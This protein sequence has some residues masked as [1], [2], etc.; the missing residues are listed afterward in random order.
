M[1]D[2]HAS[3]LPGISAANP[4][5]KIRFVNSHV[6]RQFPDQFAPLKDVFGCD[7]ESH[8]HGTMFRFPLRTP[9]LADASEIKR[10]AYSR[11]EVADLFRRFRASITE[12]MLFLRNV[13]NVEVYVQYEVGQ[14]PFL[15]FGTDVAPEDDG[16][17]WKQIDEFVRGEDSTATASMSSKRDF[18]ARLSAKP[19][20]ELPSITQVVRISTTEQQELAEF[21]SD[22]EADIVSASARCA[23]QAALNS[24]SSSTAQYLVC[25]RIGGGRAREMACAPENVS[26]KLIPWAGIAGRIDGVSTE[27]RA[28][29]FLPLP[30]RV[31]LPVH[32]NGYFE[33]S[34]N[35]RDVWHG[36]DMTGE[37]KLR[38]EWNASLL[39]DAV[40]PAYIAFLLAARELCGE[41][42]AQ[43]LALFPTRL[44][45]QPWEAIVHELFRRMKHHPVFVSH[46]Q[47][48]DLSPD[49]TS[50]QLRTST[51]VAPADCV[52]ID[53][54]I[55]R[56][57]L[58]ESAL[59]TAG[60]PTVLLPEALRKLAI[61]LDTV[62]SAMTPAFFRDLVRDG[63][64]LPRLDES[65]ARRVIEFCLHDCSG[66]AAVTP[67]DALNGLPILPLKNGTYG[68]FILLSPTQASQPK[69]QRYYLGSQVEEELLASF[70]DVVVK[71]DYR[72][73]FDALPSVFDGS[74]LGVA[75]LETIVTRFLPR[76]LGGHFKEAKSGVFVIEERSIADESTA[77]KKSPCHDWLC[78]LWQYV[79]TTLGT[80]A[81]L[82]DRLRK[83]PLLP[84]ALSDNQTGWIRLSS[85]FGIVIRQND[86]TSATEDGYDRLI[87]SFGPLG[88]Y[89]VDASVVNG[90]KSIQWLLRHKLAQKLTPGGVLASLECVQVLNGRRGY[91]DIFA[92]SSVDDRL[93]MCNFLSNGGM[94][95]IPD[96]CEHILF[97]LPI[98]PV[99]SS[100]L[101]GRTS[102]SPEDFAQ[103]FVCL[104]R[105]GYIPDATADT[106][107]L[108]SNFFRA[109]SEATRKFLRDC[110][111]DEWSNTKILL[112]F[113]FP[114]LK[115]LESVDPSLVD[116]TL[117]ATV[118]A[119]PFHQK[120]DAR[121]RA[122]V[123][124]QPII[125]S[126]KRVFRRVNEL[127]DPN[128]K[129]LSML[130]GENSLPA[131]AFAAPEIVDILRTLGLRMGLSCHAVLESARSVEAMYADES[132]AGE[133]SQAW[134]K[135]SNL[136]SIVNKHFDTMAAAL[137]QDEK[138]SCDGSSLR[139]IVDGLRDIRWLPV[140]DVPSDPL[141]P[142]K[143]GHRVN[144]T[145]KR[146]SSPSQTRPRHLAVRAS[147]LLMLL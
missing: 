75:D 99:H 117:V 43:Y 84:I 18:Y 3:N 33:L 92:H 78:L 123:Q 81:E 49:A 136:V 138:D 24:L 4:G 52:V 55:P 40:A 71:A 101:D 17:S 14:E 42:V 85:G 36:D 69:Q 86:S 61:Q 80:G 22:F 21:F 115:Q 128:S 110:G 96:S 87:E 5:L 11:R 64:L 137:Q 131:E 77:V 32:V 74:N 113:V 25:N 48:I 120:A 121:F 60:Y 50:I 132:G 143:P 58:L 88:V 76:V 38:S 51:A 108:D 39:V 16:G 144:Y 130:V 100:V 139:A 141:M 140:C 134:E 94:N 73:L 146:L 67:L 29:C 112:D 102:Q 93:A 107:L 79:E 44:P 90:D 34:S 59:T 65:A 31:G 89:V 54:T 19:E 70:P 122:F 8:F 9:E 37:G 56:W 95:T 83:L 63:Q 41:D 13:R 2:P 1:F 109:D 45:A 10:R 68:Q 30:V 111:A 91:D 66:A 135:A 27:G 103:Q 82:P 126:R 114:R 125:P 147:L 26:L 15:L 72:P 142:W 127:H 23:S 119:L 62:K 98:F 116:E 118:S 6:V 7:L 106:R 105:G 20:E 12:T 124:T 28:F 104:R 129:E 47:R 35:R 57:E 53:D 145:H 46:N 133:T 97:D